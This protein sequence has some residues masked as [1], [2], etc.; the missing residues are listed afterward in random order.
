MST[1]TIILAVLGPPALLLGWVLVQHAWRRQ[2]ISTGEQD[3]LAVRGQ[4]GRCSCATPCTEF[5][6]EAGN[7]T[8]LKTQGDLQ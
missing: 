4:C 8:Q 6:S 7:K 5:L 1:F 2:F 3:A